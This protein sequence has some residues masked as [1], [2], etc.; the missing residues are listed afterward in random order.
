MQT[1]TRYT[2]KGH[3]KHHQWPFYSV[4]YA[5]DGSD[6]SQPRAQNTLPHQ[7]SA[8]SENRVNIGLFRH[9]VKQH[10]GSRYHFFNH[11]RYFFEL[12]SILIR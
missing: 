2:D 4:Q 3:P 5:L 8:P 12:F 9:N 10:V 7:Q 6:K 11:N 1:I